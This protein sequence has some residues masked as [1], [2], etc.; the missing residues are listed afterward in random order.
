MQHVANLKKI[1]IV[2]MIAKQ[3]PFVRREKSRCIKKTLLQ[4]P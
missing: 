4:C 1:I 2:R 3:K